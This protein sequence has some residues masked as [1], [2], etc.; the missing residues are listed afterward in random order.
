MLASCIKAKNYVESRIDV[1][2]SLIFVLASENRRY[3]VP[4]FKKI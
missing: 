1:L 4:Y 2:Q 3:T